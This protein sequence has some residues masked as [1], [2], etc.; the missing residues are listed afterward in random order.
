[1][2][3]IV[4]YQLNYDLQANCFYAAYQ[5]KIAPMTTLKD[6]LQVL[7]DFALSRVVTFLAVVIT[8]FPAKNGHHFIMIFHVPKNSNLIKM[9]ADCTCFTILLKKKLEK[10]ELY[11]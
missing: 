6:G 10:R 2:I 11:Y 9:F 4:V 8:C 5:S 3:I 7:K 1:L